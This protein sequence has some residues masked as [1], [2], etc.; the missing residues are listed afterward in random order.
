MLHSWCYCEI[1]LK[2]EGG[3]SATLCLAMTSLYRSLGCFELGYKRLCRTAGRCLLAIHRINTRVIS[4]CGLCCCQCVIAWVV[5]RR[6]CAVGW[7]VRMR[8]FVEG[9]GQRKRVG[10]EASH[11]GSSP[12]QFALH[13]GVGRYKLWQK[14]GLFLKYDPDEQASGVVETKDRAFHFQDVWYVRMHEWV[15][16][17]SEATKRPWPYRKEHLGALRAIFS[18]MW[19]DLGSADNN[20][21][22]SMSMNVRVRLHGLNVNEIPWSEMCFIG[23][24][25][26]CRILTRVFLTI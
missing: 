19:R 25:P 26:H 24:T 12:V 5:I 2:G 11:V 9:H 3:T 22:S 18:E 15:D 7:M 14:K 8:C 17:A 21:C 10:C 20:V 1:S 16:D 23:E 13:L 4:T 6:P